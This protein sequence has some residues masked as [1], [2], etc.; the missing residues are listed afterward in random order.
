MHCLTWREGDCR[1]QVIYRVGL[2]LCLLNIMACEPS[3]GP[4]NNRLSGSTPVG[5]VR[6]AVGAMSLPPLTLDDQFERIAEQ[7]P[8]FAGVYFAGNE[9]VVV[10][11]DLATDLASVRASILGTIERPRL[12]TS[13]MKAVQGQFSWSQLYSWRR[14]LP[15]LAVIPQVVELGI[16]VRRNRLRVGISDPS[17]RSGVLALLKSLGVPAYATLIEEESP[18]MPTMALNSRWGNP[19]GGIYITQRYD[20]LT[21][22][23]AGTVTLFCTLGYNTGTHPYVTFMTN[24]HCSRTWATSP[25]DGTVYYQPDFSSSTFAIGQ[26]EF[27]PSSFTSAFDSRCPPNRYCRY[28]DASMNAYDAS[29]QA[30]VIVGAIARPL[31]RAS[32]VADTTTQADPNNLLMSITGKWH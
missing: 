18:P 32:S 21:G 10:L 11:T 20:S 1:K 12:R 7:Q 17:A 14:R 31:R 30:T 15:S 28:S 6:N 4:R 24:G 9:A 27:E 8:A 5:P 25:W 29:I 26:E 23:T 22:T 16:D 2:S 13:H 3:T 19:V